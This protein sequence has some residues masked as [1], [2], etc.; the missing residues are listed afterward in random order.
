[1]MAYLGSTLLVG[2]GGGLGSIARFAIGRKLSE[3]TSTW[4]PIGTFFVNITGA[5]LFGI[6]SGLGFHGNMLL[7]LGDGFLGAYT[8]FSTFMYEGFNLFKEN[9]KKNALVYMIGAF[10]LG[11]AG[12]I[13]GIISCKLFLI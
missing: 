3:A 8:T 4:F 6:I 10:I 1:M 13:I 2:L 11:I 5:I 12:F 9:E 7:L